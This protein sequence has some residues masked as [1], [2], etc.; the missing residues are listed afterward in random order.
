MPSLS[1]GIAPALRNLRTL[2][3]KE[4]ACHMVGEA[5]LGLAPP[6]RSVGQ[7]SLTHW[8]LLPSP[9]LFYNNIVLLLLYPRSTLTVLKQ[10]Y[11][12]S[13]PAM[14]PRL[15]RYR[16]PTTTQLSLLPFPATWSG[17]V[18]NLIGSKL[19]ITPYRVTKSARQRGLKGVGPGRLVNSICVLI[20]RENGRFCRSPSLSLCVC[21]MIHPG[22]RHCGIF[23]VWLLLAHFYANNTRQIG[24]I[25]R[26]LRSTAGTTRLS[27]ASLLH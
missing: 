11:F 12:T 14:R 17:G 25:F 3:C 27:I 13:I 22:D 9:V 16:L 20:S 21:V 15:P 26:P 10:A 24:G 4:L 2:V 23:P 18:D 8:L 1:G 5:L 19:I 7:A 6:N